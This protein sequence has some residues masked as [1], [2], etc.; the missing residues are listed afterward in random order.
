MTGYRYKAAELSIFSIIMALIGF[1]IVVLIFSGTLT[2][3]PDNAVQ[4]CFEI[5][6]LACHI[7]T[8]LGFLDGPLAWN[9]GNQTNCLVAMIA[10]S[11]LSLCAFT[12][13][14]LESLVIATQLIEGIAFKFLNKIPVL[15]CFGFVSP[16]LYLVLVI[17]LAYNDLIPFERKV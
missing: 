7:F 5:S 14:F 11:Y 13:L 16:M 6:L 1:S 10:L 2:I 12:F 8:L 4:L 3:Y 17:P 15:I 9:P